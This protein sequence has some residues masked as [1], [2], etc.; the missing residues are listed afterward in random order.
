M[1]LT[2]HPD[3][4][5]LCPPTRAATLVDALAA[6]FGLDAGLLSERAA[7]TGWQRGGR[8]TLGGGGRLLRAEDDWVALSLPRPEDVELVPAL[9]EVDQPVDGGLWPVVESDVA[10]RRADDVVDRARFLGLAAARLA[11]APVAATP[12]WW[13]EARPGQRDLAGLHVVDLSGLWAGPLCA[14]LL[15]RAGAQVTKVESTRRPDGARR[16]DPDFYDLL[17]AG[18]ESVALDLTATAGRE[19]L[20]PLVAGADVVITAARPRAVAGLG[21][22][23][24]AMTSGDQCW[25]A[26]TAR[27]W[28]DESVGFG[29]DVAAGAGLVA[30]DEGGAPCFAGDAIADPLC[31][32]VAAA[33]VLQGAVG[34]L[35]MSMEQVA[36]LAV[37]P[38]GATRTARRQVDPEASADGWMLEDEPVARPRRRT[39]AERA[40]TLGADTATV[41]ER[42]AR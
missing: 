37:E 10:R 23:P 2:G 41:M 8:T 19:A 6:P 3:G 36:S 29:D 22:D 1:M 42:V 38:A 16:G 26:I 28:G 7:L 31:G 13:P 34:V 40:A 20:G 24:V 9:L 17:N 30:W 27:G 5:P 39:V 32:V 35:D 14:A 33:A 21:L 4:P 18:K 15:L 11:G 12:P 25:V